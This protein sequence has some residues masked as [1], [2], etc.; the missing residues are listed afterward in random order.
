M[1]EVAMNK[2]LLTFS[3]GTICGLL[4][5]AA[6]PVLSSPLAQ[7]PDCPRAMPV[8]TYITAT[9]QVSICI[10]QDGSWFYRGVELANHENSINLFDLRETDENAYFVRNGD[11]AYEIDPEQ[12]TVFQN[13]RIIWQE[14]V[15]SWS[16]AEVQSRR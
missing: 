5:Y 1:P 13:G 3:F 15:L 14:P 12:L 7:T 4:S 11:F 6:Q 8:A 10:G 9:Y 16:T 2:S